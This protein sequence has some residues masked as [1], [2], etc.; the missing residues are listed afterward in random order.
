MAKAT[1]VIE[2]RVPTQAEQEAEAMQE[3]MSAVAKNKDALL[4]F[5]DVLGELQESGA[6][7]MAHG[8]LKSRHQIGVIG[9][10]QLNK[11][12]AQN[13]IKNG[14]S[15]VQFLAQLDPNKLQ[16]MLGAVASGVDSAVTAEEQRP[17]KKPGLYDLFKRMRDPQVTSALGMMLNFL[18]G[19]GA[20]KGRD[21]DGN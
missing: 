15:T 18:R 4:T 13:I 17:Q 1:T 8:A 12:G 10:G 2:K 3:V 14:M 9:I 5:L 11:S 16:T 7:D 21:G 6:L 19:M 20:A